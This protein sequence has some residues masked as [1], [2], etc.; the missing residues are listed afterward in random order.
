MTMAMR[1]NTRVLV[2][3]AVLRMA[4]RDMTYSAKTTKVTVGGL[5]HLS[6]PSKVVLEGE[7][8]TITALAGL[9][10]AAGGV[11]IALKPASVKMKG[12]VKVESGSKATFTGAPDDVTA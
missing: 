10:L 4:G 7:V 5:A 8:I 12:D 2:G 6:S 1:T 11:E 9:V 3:G